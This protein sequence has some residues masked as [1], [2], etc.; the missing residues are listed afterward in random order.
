MSDIKLFRMQGQ[1][2]S[3][4]PG[5]SVAVE[6]S[7]QHMIESNLEAFLGIRFLKTEHSTGRTHGGRIDTLGLDENNSPVIIEY[8]RAVN[9]NVINQGLYYL[10]WLLDHRAEFELMVMREYGADVSNA[11]DWSAPRLL[12]IAGDFKKHDEHAVRQINRNIELIRYKRFGEDLVLFDLVN[13]TTAETTV[14]S[15]VDSGTQRTA[16]RPTN[17]RTIE[18]RLASAPAEVQDRFESLKTYLLALGDD[19]QFKILKHYFAFAGLRNFACVEVHPQGA[20]IVLYLKVDP[21][22]IE[23][24]EGFTR[25]VRKIG[26]YGTGDLEVT[27]R[28]DGDLERAK[29]L[30]LKSYETA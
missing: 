9:E 29:H 11:I 28:N 20:L 10:D 17:T 16:R 23:T 19:V 15:Q 3:E 25:D 1:S 27:V 12:C 6:K 24:E 26:H 22:S 5:T 4:L 2:V 21:D 8:K 30:V 18:D 14:E 13:V 7:L